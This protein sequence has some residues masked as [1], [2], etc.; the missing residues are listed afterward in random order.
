MS[1]RL[2][3]AGGADA[4]PRGTTTN[5]K[6]LNHKQQLLVD[7]KNVLD[8][9]RER[10]EV[11]RWTLDVF[12]EVARVWEEEVR[13]G[14]GGVAEIKESL[15]QIQ[16]KLITMNKRIANQSSKAE[17]YAGVAESC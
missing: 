5:I 16:E 8:I 2:R 3:S 11:K 6:P 1:Q 10:H 9:K 7:L 14:S 15:K 17:T 4:I 13:K 12:E